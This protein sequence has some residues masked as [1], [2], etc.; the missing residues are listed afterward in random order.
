MN[1]IVIANDAVG[2]VE[3]DPA[4][5]GQIGLHPGMGGYISGEA[6]AIGDEDITPKNR[7]S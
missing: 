2:G 3:V 1:Q 4:G 5:T 6:G 7:R